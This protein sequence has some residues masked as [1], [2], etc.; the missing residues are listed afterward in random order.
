[1]RRFMMERLDA[2]NRAK[3]RK[4]LVL[5][6]ARQVG[7]TWL[8]KEFGRL[9]FDNVAY[10]NFDNNSVLARQF[11]Q[12]YDLSRILL[13]MQAQSRIKIDARNTLV[14]M[15]EIQECPRALTSLK[16]FAEQMPEL[17]IIAAGSLLGLTVHSGTGYPVG[18]V[19][20]L[21]LYPLNFREFLLA[22]EGEGL[23]EII[24]SGDVASIE[25]FAERLKTAL[26]HYYYVGGMP[27]AVDAFIGDRDFTSA[28]SIQ[29]TILLGYERDM[30]KHLSVKETEAALAVWNSIPGHLG[31][32]NKRFI[33][34][35]VKEGARAREYRSAVS[36]LS[37]AGLVYRVPRVSKPGIPLKSYIENDIFKLFV[38]DVGLL[39]ALSGL[40]LQSVLHQDSVFSEF[41]GAMT[42]QYVCQELISDCGFTP[43]YWSANNSRGEIDFMVQDGGHIYP[44][45][46]KAAENLRSKSLRAF[47]D[48]YENMACRRFSLSGFRKESWM[49]NVPL[50]LVGEKRLWSSDLP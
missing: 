47:N 17:A 49:I 3:A 44:I 45:E 24:D 2:W 40:D 33:F 34:G 31:Q 25:P 20:E 11:D 28:R 19:S 9:H 27:E 4:P 10:F 6:G 43:F 46:V 30:S 5:N 21:D 32:E 35:H 13:A 16:Y 26:N 29:N 50:Y 8:A 12:D 7:K 23:L 36:W 39:G 42:E 22:T 15:D 18:K 37:A 1:M 48:R 41:K 14:I 38:V